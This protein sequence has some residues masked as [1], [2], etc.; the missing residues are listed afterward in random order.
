MKYISKI[1]Y[2]GFTKGKSY[3][4]IEATKSHY[5]FLNDLGDLKTSRKEN[6][7]VYFTPYISFTIPNFYY[8]LKTAFK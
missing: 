4:C 5:H 3:K 7:L 8:R 2:K 1:D 6:I